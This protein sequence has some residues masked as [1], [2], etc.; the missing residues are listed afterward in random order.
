[1]GAEGGSWGGEATAGPS[2]RC[3]FIALSIPL[4]PLQSGPTGPPQCAVRPD[5]QAW[6]QEPGGGGEGWAGDAGWRSVDWLPSRTGH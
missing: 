3:G 6:K 5:L 4:P 1:M 2:P